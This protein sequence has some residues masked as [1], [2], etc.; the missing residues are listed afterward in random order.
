MTHILVI[1][2]SALGDVA[3]LAPVLKT[4]AKANPDV[5]FTIAAP[6]LL[7]P[8][9]D[10]VDNIH[11]L[12]VNKKDG[13]R[14]IYQQLLT[15]EADAI[16]DLHVVNRVGYALTMLQINR[17]LH[18]KFPLPQYRLNKGR[19]SR[20]LFLHRLSHRPRRPQWQRYDDV[21]TRML[22][23][24]PATVGSHSRHKNRPISKIG[25]APF[26]QHRGKIWPIEYT[27]QLV[28]MLDKHGYSIFLFGGKD[29]APRLEEIASHYEHAESLAG[30]YTFAEELDIIRNIDVMVSMDSSNMHFA[31]AVGTPVVSIWGAT[32][33]DFGFYGYRQPRDLALCAD[34]PCQPCSAYGRKPCRYGDYRCLTAI[35]PEAVMQKIETLGK[36]C[37]TDGKTLDGK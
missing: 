20:W 32:H 1:R 14:A 12:G 13:T 16:A 21:F 17:I 29:E 24:Q 5:I 10:G 33:P 35:S 31:S 36:I 37:P 9:F 27:E 6:P 30:R 4:R 11:F 2:L 28:E 34:L 18:F 26:A 25:I 19:L 7:Q 22:G 23:D 8:L 15:V 3:I